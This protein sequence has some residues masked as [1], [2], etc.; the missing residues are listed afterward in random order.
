MKPQKNYPSFA[1]KKK[2]TEWV[3]LPYCT[4]AEGEF[5]LDEH[6][7]NASVATCKAGVPSSEL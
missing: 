5:K 3:E 6:L 2:S 1:D 7:N 4:G